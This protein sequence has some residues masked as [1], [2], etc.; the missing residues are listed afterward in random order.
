MNRIPTH[1]KSSL[2]AVPSEYN[3]I[4]S[5][6]PTSSLS[7]YF[8]TDYNNQDEFIISFNGP[9]E[10]MNEPELMIGVNNSDSNISFNLSQNFFH[11][12][13]MKLL[14]TNCKTYPY[15]YIKW[16]YSHDKKDHTE[17]ITSIFR[18]LNIP[19][20]SMWVWEVIK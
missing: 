20:H 16:G 17:Y 5:Y 19:P 2:W 18:E 14:F 15:K 10:L 6:K 7:S 3:H 9:G 12:F 13:H 4:I 8:C 1:L 11:I